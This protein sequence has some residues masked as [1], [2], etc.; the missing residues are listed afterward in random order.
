MTPAKTRRA[1]LELLKAGDL[2]LDQAER[3]LDRLQPPKRMRGRPKKPRIC[4]RG[5]DGQLVKLL[6]RYR[7]KLSQREAEIARFYLGFIAGGAEPMVAMEETL[8]K[9]RTRRS[10]LEA[11]SIRVYVY[12]FKK[13]RAAIKRRKHQ[14]QAAMDDLS[15]VRLAADILKRERL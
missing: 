8:K 12:L 2:T 13:A 5:E 15:G 3:E 1:I 9:Y 6:G 14:I 10:S 7:R 11:D 4:I